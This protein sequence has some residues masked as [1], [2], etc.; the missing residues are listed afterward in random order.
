MKNKAPYI[1]KIT[2]EF[3]NGT[4]REL[5][6]KQFISLIRDISYETAREA[7]GLAS[8]RVEASVCSSASVTNH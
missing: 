1:K 4:A 6:R 5:A 8:K 2:V 3:S 7:L